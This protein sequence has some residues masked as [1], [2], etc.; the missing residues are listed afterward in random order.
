M[1]KCKPERNAK[2]QAE[3]IED[4]VD[5]S[6]IV[7]GKLNLDVK[8]VELLPVI[9]AAVDIVRPAADARRLSLEVTSDGVIGPVS[10][11][12]ARLQQV[13]WNLLS[14]AVKF[15]SGGGR[16]RVYLRRNRSWAEVVV[17]DTGRGIHPDF[18]P[19]VFERFRQAEPSLTR[20]HGGLGLGLAIVRHLVEL[21]GGTVSAESPG[22]NQG[23][24]FT[25]RLPL[26]IAESTDQQSGSDD[27]QS[28]V[29]IVRRALTGLRVLVVED[30]PDARELLLLTLESSGAKVE[31]VSSA[32]DAL[33]NLQIFQPHVLLSDIGLPVESG[34]E[35][36]RKIRSLPTQ[37]SQVPAV[38]LTAFATEKDHQMALS[39][40]FQIYLAK[41]IDPNVLV[42]VIERV[43]N[44]DSNHG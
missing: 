6:R 19:R 35:L 34:Y 5:V 39:A 31:A 8:P 40:G 33:D 27:F 37:S 14:N 38:A 44:R 36:I 28:E 30:E 1:R 24:T 7:G 13:I 15:T 9:A 32:R 11:D 23:A 20:A 2:V 12:P 42:E 21:H 10:G 4:L 16:V 17:A 41:P 43:A 25:I 22:E 29:T 18:L 26:A 3:L